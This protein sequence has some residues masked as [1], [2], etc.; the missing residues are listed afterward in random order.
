MTQPVVPGESYG[1]DDK[2][3]GISAEIRSAIGQQNFEHWFTNRSRFEISGNILQIFVPNPFISNWL[4][5][6][7]RS[8]FNKAAV[9]LLGP[10]GS[11]ELAVDE[12]LQ[13]KTSDSDSGS[14]SKPAPPQLTTGAGSF[15]I[16]TSIASSCHCQPALGS[17]TP[18]HW[19]GLRF[20]SG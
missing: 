3:A 10:S 9:A 13:H 16:A 1:R 19:R 15:A 8:Q 2:C 12:T 4:V 18:G 6:R 14:A 17:G 11:F 20:L 7:F 5:K